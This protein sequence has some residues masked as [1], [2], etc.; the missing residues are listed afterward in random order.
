MI[1][2]NSLADAYRS[3]SNE[4][5]IHLTESPEG[6]EPAARS[7]LLSELEQRQKLTPGGPANQ[8][9]DWHEVVVRGDGIQFPPL[10]PSCLLQRSLVP[11]EF[12]SENVR[13][14][15]LIYTGRKKVKLGIPH[16]EDCARRI[17]RKHI[18]AL[19]WELLAI[20]IAG[21]FTLLV[22]SDAGIR[23]KLY[24]FLFLATVL[25]LPCGYIVRRSASVELGEFDADHL[26][27]WFRS[28]EYAKAFEKVNV[29]TYGPQKAEADVADEIQQAIRR[30]RAAS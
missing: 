12:V 28:L 19:A 25:S 16:C 8:A 30:L 3:M 6:L 13:T 22:D 17:K 24:I 9:N 27:F 4:E 14:A 23:S 26:T 21:V 7:T 5:L 18:H 2:T 29:T 10:C 15:R 11:V 20:S 1:D